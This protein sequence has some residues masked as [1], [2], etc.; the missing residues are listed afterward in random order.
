M[1]QRVKETLGLRLLLLRTRR[2]W[3]LADLERRTK[4]PQSMLSRYERDLSSPSAGRLA[5]LA[6]ALGTTPNYLLGFGGD[7][8]TPG[9]RIPV[10]TMVAA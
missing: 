3:T 6:K 1:A 8:L 2:R 10:E 4:I 5:K 9:K 7:R